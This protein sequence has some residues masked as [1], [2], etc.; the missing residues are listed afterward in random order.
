M[1]KISHDFRDPLGFTSITGV[2]TLVLILLEAVCIPGVLES[3]EVILNPE[4]EV[5]MV[6]PEVTLDSVLE[7]MLVL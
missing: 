3:L 2:A 1:R 4:L 7:T 5:L 6:S